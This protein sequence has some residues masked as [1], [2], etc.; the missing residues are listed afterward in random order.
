MAD[1]NWEEGVRSFIPPRLRVL[2]PIILIDSL[3]STSS[4][5]FKEV[6]QALAQP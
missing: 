2:G 5:W 3:M 6:T 1:V 4:S